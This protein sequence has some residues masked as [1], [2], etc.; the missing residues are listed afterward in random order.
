MSDRN[1]DR[2]NQQMKAV[3]L[4]AN[5]LAQLTDW[6]LTHTSPRDANSPHELLAAGVAALAAAEDAG[7]VRASRTN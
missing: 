6:G 7:L 3:G 5:A 1:R 4:L 2:Y